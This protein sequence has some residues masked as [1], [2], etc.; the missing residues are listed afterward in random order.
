MAGE[1]AFRR[2][3]LAVA[4]VSTA[5]FTWFLTLGRAD[6]VQYRGFG[7]V[8]DLQARAF[9]DGR[10]SV[11]DGSL[12]FEGFVV[13]GRTYAYFG[14]FP[15]LLRMPLFL[16]TDRFD[17]RLSAVSMLVAYVIALWSAISVI[18]RV[19]G[20]LRPGAPW[21]RAGL[22]AAAA[23]MAAVGLG[24]NLLF[25]ASGAWVYHEASLWGA[26]GVLA[27]F[28]ATL[29]Y[30]DRGRLR[31]VVVAGLWAAVAWTSRGSVGLAPSVVLGL[32]GLARLTGHPWP[33]VLAPPPE[34]RTDPDQG[35]ARE[36]GGQ[37]DGATDVTGGR[38]EG[39]RGGGADAATGEPAGRG[40]GRPVA[41]SGPPA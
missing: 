16:V 14:V 5:V 22:V 26:A 21:T 27:A 25:L 40:S 12:A 30:L 24:S 6:L 18:G 9:L 8:F 28:A 39:R 32:L 35:A 1:R 11:P 19:R 17:G 41:G 31:S 23:L 33:A 34:G 37:G 7:E 36:P 20:L 15:S 3:A 10:L 13:G 2:T 29:R 38:G 4:V